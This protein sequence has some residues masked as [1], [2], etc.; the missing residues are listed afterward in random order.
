MFFHLNYQYDGD[1][2][3]RLVVC[4]RAHP[5]VKAQ[6]AQYGGLVPP[7]LNMEIPTHFL[8]GEQ[9]TILPKIEFN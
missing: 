7:T 5:W 6:F 3:T 4:S 9:W 1:G 2:R 8:E